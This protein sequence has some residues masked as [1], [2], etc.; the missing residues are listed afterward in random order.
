MVAGVINSNSY[1]HVRLYMPG[2]KRLTSATKK[3]EKHTINVI[4][5]L[6][7]AETEKYGYPSHPYSGANLDLAVKSLLWKVAL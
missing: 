5:R 7:L 4:N 6:L 3:M 2:W 1:D